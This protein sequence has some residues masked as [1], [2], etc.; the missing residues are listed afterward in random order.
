MAIDLRSMSLKDLKKLKTD[1]E[2]AVLSAEK[3]ALQEARK[4]AETAAAKF[5]F[6]LDEVTGGKGR[7]AKR[8]KAAAK[9]RNPAN[10]DQTWSGRGRKPAWI[11]EALSK[12]A[13]ITDLEI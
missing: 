11:H 8:A 7:G 13:D 2:K 1:V 4:A 9:Y 12:G 6:S 3:N 5:G 10:P